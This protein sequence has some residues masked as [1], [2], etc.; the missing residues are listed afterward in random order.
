M[1]TDDWMFF[2]ADIFLESVQYGNRTKMCDLLADNASST[3]DAIV[4]LMTDFGHNVAGVNPGDYDTR[5]IADTT[6]DVNSSA[7]P[8]TF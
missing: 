5:V 6:V 1:R 4:Q 3:Q 7:R 2:Y 8:W